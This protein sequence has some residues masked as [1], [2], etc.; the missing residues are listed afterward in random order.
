MSDSR[1]TRRQFLRMVAGSAA[2]GAMVACAPA[3]APTAIVLPTAVPQ[4]PEDKPAE[5]ERR[6]VV[7]WYSMGV[8]D[9]AIWGETMANFVQEV[10]DP[11]FTLKV[12]YIAGAEHATK[13][14]A[15]GSRRSMS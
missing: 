1:M 15:S 14:D 12:E 3:V 7:H 11:R 2:V 6:E 8:A 4:R 5:V 10:S 13:L 9:G